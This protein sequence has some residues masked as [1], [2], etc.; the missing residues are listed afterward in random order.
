MQAGQIHGRHFRLFCSPK[1][2]RGKCHLRMKGITCSSSTWSLGG[3]E[4]SGEVVLKKHTNSS[5]SV[6]VDNKCKVDKI[7]ESQKL[8][9]VM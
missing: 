2:P 4:A 5:I 3:K 7:L 8:T 9:Q 1:K 6:S